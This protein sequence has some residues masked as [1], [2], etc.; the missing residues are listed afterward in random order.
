MQVEAHLP[1]QHL[2][3]G[4]RQWTLLKVGNLALYFATEKGIINKKT[5]CIDWRWLE[6]WLMIVFDRI[7]TGHVEFA[8]V[9]VGVEELVHI[10]DCIASGGEQLVAFDRFAV[11]RT[12]HIHVVRSVAGDVDQNSTFTGQPAR[13]SNGQTEQLDQRPALFVLVL[14]K[15]IEHDRHALLQG[16]S[17]LAARLVLVEDE[18]R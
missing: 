18:S 8:G 3:V 12:E 1:G 5:I 16:D 13:L 9:R 11:R 4:D 7:D 6:V 17:F 14:Q 15:R 2:Q 10:V